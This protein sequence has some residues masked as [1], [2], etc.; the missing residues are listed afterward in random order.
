M[1]PRIP[2]F[3]AMP[4]L[5][6]VRNGEP[7]HGAAGV[8]DDSEAVRPVVAS[9]E[10]LDGPQR[11]LLTTAVDLLGPVMA[12]FV[13]DRRSRHGDQGKRLLWRPI[14]AELRRRWEARL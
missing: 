14:A 4:A 11:L 12:T 7:R 2:A 3:S 9:S 6:A 8:A 13:A 1:N 5:P 10:P